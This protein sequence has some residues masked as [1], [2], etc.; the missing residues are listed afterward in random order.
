MAGAVLLT[1]CQ[2]RSQVGS[3]ARERQMTSAAA[4][5]ERSR[6]ERSFCKA[7]P[8]Q[9]RAANNASTRTVIVL[10]LQQIGYLIAT[11][12]MCCRLSTAIKSQVLC[13]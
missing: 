4:G 8:I 12:D 9:R 6:G 7:C 2:A 13:C 5:E 1:S 10:Q 3:T 11:H